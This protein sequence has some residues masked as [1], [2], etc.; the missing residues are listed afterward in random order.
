MS[1]R[2]FPIAH[3]I[4]QP[5]VDPVTIWPGASYFTLQSQI[6]TPEVLIVILA[7]MHL[8]VRWQ[9]ADIDRSG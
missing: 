9:S 8:E 4:F 6:F 5:V 1:K 3:T 7:G 2:E